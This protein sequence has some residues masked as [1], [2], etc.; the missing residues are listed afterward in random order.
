MNFSHFPGG[1]AFYLELAHRGELNITL[2]NCNQLGYLIRQIRLRLKGLKT[3]GHL[4]QISKLGLHNIKVR[5]AN[6]HLT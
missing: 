3:L 2:A 1:K 6:G 4:V 5:I